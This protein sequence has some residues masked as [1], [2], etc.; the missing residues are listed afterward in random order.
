MSSGLYGRGFR[1]PKAARSLVAAAKACVREPIAIME[2]CGGHTHAI[3]RY[4]LRDALAPE[5][6]L[7]SGPGCPVCVTDNRDIDLAIALAQE[8]GITVATFGDMVRVPGTM[9]S[10][11]DARAK[12]ASVEI[13]YSALDALAMARSKPETDVVMLGIGFET[14]APTVAATLQTAKSESL[15]NFFVLSLHK[16]TPPAMR[17]ILDGGEVRVDGVLGPGHVT[18]ITGSD[19]W[20]FLPEVYG[21]PCAV[22]GFEPLDILLSVRDLAKALATAEPAVVNAYRRGVTAQ[23]NVA[24][25]DLMAQVFVISKARWRG[26]GVIPDSGLDLAPAYARFDA[27]RRFSPALPSGGQGSEAR[28]CRCGDVLRGLIPPTECP[29]FGVVCTPTRPVGPCMVSAEG[30]CAAYYRYGRNGAA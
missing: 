25:Q 13:V 18:A 7:L 2:F 24:A 15:A 14:T 1:D 28:G 8:P 27:R 5:I 30:A 22:S 19:A 20:E 11:A 3:M 26:L 6:R 12:G 23:G 21:V 10:L 9:G 4:G 17:A 16:L 29:L